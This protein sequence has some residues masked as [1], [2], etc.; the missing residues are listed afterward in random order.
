MSFSV[1]FSIPP[2]E[3]NRK[4]LIA[5]IDFLQDTYV[6]GNHTFIWVCPISMKF[7]GISIK[8]YERPAGDYYR[9]P[10]P[11]TFQIISPEIPGLPNV[12]IPLT[13]IPKK[14]YYQLYN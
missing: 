6:L 8:R 9:E 2:S 13:D 7:V 10:Y 1:S 11:M 3:E 5:C 14:S 4:K 12:I